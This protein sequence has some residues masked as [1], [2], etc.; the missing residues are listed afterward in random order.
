MMIVLCATWNPEVDAH[1][2]STS[3]QHVVLLLARAG[4]MAMT[5]PCSLIRVEKCSV[6]ATLRFVSC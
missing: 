6:F 2:S 4:E 3:D 5:G 1:V